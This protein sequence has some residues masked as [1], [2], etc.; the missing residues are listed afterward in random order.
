MVQC[1]P[2]FSRVQ[3]KLCC[4]AGAPMVVTLPNHQA[5]N[6]GK[7]EQHHAMRLFHS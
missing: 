2:V 7:E 6:R 4:K 1:S 3:R 5:G